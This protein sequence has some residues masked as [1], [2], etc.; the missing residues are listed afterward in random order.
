M[1]SGVYM[2]CD[3]RTNL[4]LASGLQSRWLAR[5]SSGECPDLQLRDGGDWK[6][7]STGVMMTSTPPTHPAIAGTVVTIGSG[8]FSFFGSTLVVVQWLAAA[9]AVVAGVL[10]I[11]H[12]IKTWNS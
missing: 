6:G 1:D 5:Q 10:T 7:T 4:P 8:A 12:L 3:G 11:I 9:V 2:D